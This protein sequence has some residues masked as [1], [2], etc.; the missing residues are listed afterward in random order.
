MKT[1]LPY[2]LEKGFGTFSINEA[3]SIKYANGMMELVITPLPAL[4]EEPIFMEIISREPGEIRDEVMRHINTILAIYR[5]QFFED[6]Q[7][8]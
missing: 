2:I 4:N 8:I 5:D 7:R 3:A 6:V 1:Y